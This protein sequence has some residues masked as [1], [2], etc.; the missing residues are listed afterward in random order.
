LLPHNDR[1]ELT[2][3]ISCPAHSHN[4]QPKKIFSFQTMYIARK[5]KLD[6][7]QM[8]RKH[9]LPSVVYSLSLFRILLQ[10]SLGQMLGAAE[11]SSLAPS[12]PTANRTSTHSV[13]PRSL[14]SASSCSPSSF[15]VLLSSTIFKSLQNYSPNLFS[16][17]QNLHW[18]PP[19]ALRKSSHFVPSITNRLPP[20]RTPLHQF[21][22]IPSLYFQPLI[23][24][25]H[26]AHTNQEPTIQAISCS[27][28]GVPQ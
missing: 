22:P 24:M 11:S 15:P 10:E 28:N 23:P 8:L 16:C 9:Q 14:T 6:F 5:H 13:L 12:S 1:T 27:S 26:S 21:D 25:N 7:H 19:E 20:L 17:H 3:C 2:R 18:L 4:F